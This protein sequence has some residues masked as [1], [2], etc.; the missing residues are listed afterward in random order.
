MT[1]AELA[2]RAGVTT[3]VISRLERGVVEPSWPTARNLAIALNV[4]P[5]ALFPDAAT[6]QAGDPVDRRSA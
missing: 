5:L 1:Q 4:N 6:E 2:R 3:A